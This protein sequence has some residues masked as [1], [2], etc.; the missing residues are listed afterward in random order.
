DHDPGSLRDAI[1]TT[2]AGGTVDFQPGL[3][4]TITLTSGELAIDKDLTIAG[5]G[6]DVITVSG[7]HAS[8]VFEIGPTFTVAISGLTIFNGSVGD[9]G[10]GI[11]NRGTLIVSD[12]TLSRNSSGSINGGGAIFNA[13]TLTVTDSTIS[14]NSGHNDGGAIYNNGA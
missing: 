3:R 1:A 13:G 6:A 9:D 7:N 8:R 5:P 10:G 2:P 12:C 11:L 4:G 14:D